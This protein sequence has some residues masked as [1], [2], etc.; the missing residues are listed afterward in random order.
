MENAFLNVCKTARISYFSNKKQENRHFSL[1][2]PRPP[3][4][5]QY[6]RCIFSRNSSRIVCHIQQTVISFRFFENSFK[7][8]MYFEKLWVFHIPRQHLEGGKMLRPS[9][10]R[11]KKRFCDV[12]ASLIVQIANKENRGRWGSIITSGM[13]FAF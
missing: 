6:A 8:E 12:M 7:L 5:I 1:F 2:L 3:L 10:N 11:Y 4:L 9:L 13:N